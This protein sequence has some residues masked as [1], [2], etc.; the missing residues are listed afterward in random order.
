MRD[1]DRELMWRPER[2]RALTG[3]LVFGQ[4]D[5]VMSLCHEDGL[6]FIY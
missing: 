3:L 5:V 2:A 6:Y 4:H 1:E